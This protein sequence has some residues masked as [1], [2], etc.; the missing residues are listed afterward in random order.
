MA[1][2]LDWQ[3][4]AP[5]AVLHPGF[6]CFENPDLQAKHPTWLWSGANMPV[7]FF[8]FSQQVPSSLSSSHQWR[9]AR[10]IIEG[11]LQQRNV[12]CISESCMN[13]TG[14]RCTIS[15]F[16]SWWIHQASCRGTS[17][18]LETV[19]FWL[20]RRHVCL[21]AH[22]QVLWVGGCPGHNSQTLSPGHCWLLTV[23]PC[24]RSPWLCKVHSCPQCPGARV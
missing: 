24:T 6:P 10:S 2:I 16:V 8:A 22:C 11:Y 23:L 3:R 15:F 18:C 19:I 21:A 7:V 14:D 1:V 13:G 20:N 4:V 17:G 12:C 5:P 9:Y